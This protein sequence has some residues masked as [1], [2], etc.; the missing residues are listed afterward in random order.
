MRIILLFLLA[1]CILPTFEFNRRER[2]Q[3][4]FIFDINKCTGCQACQIACV[5]ENELEPERSWRQMFTFNKQ[6]L[7]DIPLFHLSLAC[8][9]CLDAP[10]MKYC[11]ALAYLRAGR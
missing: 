1:Y 5:I 6:R 8:N 4:A 11:P 10:C 9:H 3:N 2:V 7:P